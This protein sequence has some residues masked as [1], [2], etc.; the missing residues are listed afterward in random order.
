[1]LEV[2][3]VYIRA[4]E[5]K[6]VNIVPLHASVQETLKLEKLPLLVKKAG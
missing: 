4:V 5:R 6:I 1:M 3:A 2:F